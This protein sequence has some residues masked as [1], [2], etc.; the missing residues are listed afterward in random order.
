MIVE[1][2]LKSMKVILIIIGVLVA[3]VLLGYF[4]IWRPLR[5]Y[6]DTHTWATIHV[7]ASWYDADN[8]IVKDES[9]ED[10]EYLKG[11][12]IDAFLC[13]LE[14][15]KI[16]SDGDVT[17]HVSDGKT[18]LDENGNE[19]TSDTISLKEKKKYFVGEDQY[20]VIEVVS[21]RYQ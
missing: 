10:K 8:G 2:R 17:F 12:Q 14:I 20:F 1:K 19:V 15:D 16:T 13:Y 18:V 6:G 9:S 3:L 7:D 11:E 5:H 4:S 21:N